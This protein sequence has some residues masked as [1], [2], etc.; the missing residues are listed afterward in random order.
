MSIL[1][2]PANLGTLELP[3]RLLRSATAESMADEDGT[4]RAQ[5]IASNNCWAELRGVGIACICPLD[6]IAT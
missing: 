5:L 3:N 6:K 2:T 1:F 4:P